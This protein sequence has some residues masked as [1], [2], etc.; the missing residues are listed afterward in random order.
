MRRIEPL[1]AANYAVIALDLRRMKHGILVKDEAADAAPLILWLR[2]E[3]DDPS[4]FEGS[5]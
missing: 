5:H 1:I 3:H 2:L 4:A